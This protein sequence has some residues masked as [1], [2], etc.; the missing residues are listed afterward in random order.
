MRFSTLQAAEHRAALGVIRD[1]PTVK[2]FPQ[3]AA[4]RSACHGLCDCGSCNHKENNQAGEQTE[5]FG[6]MGSHGFN[7]KK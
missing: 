6:W 1:L 3:S 7:S 5:P 4:M 2:S